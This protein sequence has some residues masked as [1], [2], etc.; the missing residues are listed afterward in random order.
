[1][2]ARFLPK[3]YTRVAEPPSPTAKNLGRLVAG[4]FGDSK[5]SLRTDHHTTK[6]DQKIYEKHAGFFKDVA[7]YSDSVTDNKDSV[8]FKCQA[9]VHIRDPFSQRTVILNQESNLIIKNLFLFIKERSKDRS[10]LIGADLECPESQRT[11]KSYQTADCKS[12]G[13]FETL[14][15]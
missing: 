13:S 5:R 9:S 8:K 2:S 1:M 12:F 14:L 11:T 10:S 7:D 6:D 4:L 3:G 15:H